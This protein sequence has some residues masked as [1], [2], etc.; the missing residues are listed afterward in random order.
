M[1]SI[2]EVQFL[3]YIS[4]SG[5]IAAVTFLEPPALEVRGTKCAIRA[6]CKLQTAR[7]GSTPEGKEK[8][9]LRATLS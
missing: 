8:L 2:A 1:I 3:L 4:S 7:D 5:S 9:S 6:V